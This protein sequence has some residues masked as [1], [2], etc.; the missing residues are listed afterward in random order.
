M[1][2]GF[3][4]PHLKQ[5]FRH[6]EMENRTKVIDVKVHTDGGFLKPNKCF[7]LLHWFIDGLIKLKFSLC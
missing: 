1:L 5:F 3:G 4:A 2:D 7:N 6:F